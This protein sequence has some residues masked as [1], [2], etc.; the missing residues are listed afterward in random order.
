MEPERET[1]GIDV[2]EHVD[3]HVDDM[4]T[5][6]TID[7]DE[8]KIEKIW[9]REQYEMSMND[10]EAAANEL[11]GV[12]S[13]YNATDFENPENHYQALI[14]FDNEL[15][16]P[17]STIPA[18]VKTNYLRALRINS[19]YVSSS[20]FRLRFLRAEFFDV[21]KAILRFCKCLNVLVQYFGEVS[22]LR[23]IFLSDL[24][25]N[26]RKLLKEGELQLLPSRDSLGRRILF[27]LG[28]VG[29]NY[30][31]EER[32]RVGIYMIFQVLAEDVTT[33]QNGL[34]T[35]HVLTEDVKNSME[36]EN[37][38][39]MARLMIAFFEACPVRFSA[40]HMCFPNEFMFRFLKPLMLFLVGKAGRRVLRI[41]SGTN[42]ECYYSL[43]SFGIRLEDIPTTFSGRIKTRQHMRW[44][45]VRQTM[46]DFFNQQCKE[47]VDGEYRYFYAS[48][49]YTI[50]PF[51]HIHCPENN[52]VLFHKNGVAW[53]FP[54]NIKFRALLDEQLPMD[55]LSRKKSSGNLKST[56]ILDSAT[57]I[58]NKEKL[59]D[60]IIRLSLAQNFQFLLHDE[61]KHWYIE[62]KELD[63][64]RR[65]I[66]FAIRGHKRRVS[67]MRQRQEYSSNAN[68]NAANNENNAS[69]NSSDETQSPDF[70]NMDGRNHQPENCCYMKR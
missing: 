7:I 8:D 49:Q 65:Y 37:K 14:K 23:Q 30:T 25:K 69:G 53:D 17:N 64:L 33:Q 47:S 66:G 29:A 6:N 60:R 59:F 18:S 43:R 12:Q 10:R 51:P 40:V 58:S 20:D 9:A 31:F 54:G 35:V 46:D 50:R 61:S 15:N 1:S 42:M 28:N 16:N 32:D 38:P 24:S 22:L 44:M 67:A 3:E 5:S 62:L 45:K 41:H 55:A 48:D 39:R 26:E 68:R 36:G 70:T 63:V 56:G 13:R 27:V 34:V 2:D 4:D 11:H 21:H 52:S 19:T 57:A